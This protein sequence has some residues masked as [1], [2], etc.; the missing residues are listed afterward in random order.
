MAAETEGI[1]D[2]GV[3][4]H[5]S[6]GSRNV[7]EVALR[8]RRFQIDRGRNDVAL[9]GFDANGHF[10]CAGGSEHVACRAFG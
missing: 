6:G 7:I 1:I 8:V 4:R 10:D 9:D 5:F 3:D 2:Y